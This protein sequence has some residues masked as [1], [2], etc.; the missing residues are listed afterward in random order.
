MKVAL[1]NS[2][3]VQHP[4]PLIPFGLCRIAAAL[5]KEGHR[6]FFLDLCFSKSTSHDIRKSIKRLSPDVIGISIRNIDNGTAYKTQFFLENIRD[7]VINPCKQYFNGPIVIGGPSVGISGREMLELFDLEYAV[8]GDG[9][10]VI[11]ESDLFFMRIKL[12]LWE[13][14]PI[15]LIIKL[16]PFL[17]KGFL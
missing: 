10:S 14:K 9:E 12:I 2:N 13:K 1:I 16:F 5:E 8:R 6:V 4:W 17:L 15:E 3:R 7:K 11:I